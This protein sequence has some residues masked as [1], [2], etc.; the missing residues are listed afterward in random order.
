MNRYFLALLIVLLPSNA[1]PCSRT[2]PVDPAEMVRFA[3][4]IVVARA[5]DYD[6]A[7]SDHRITTTGVPD[8]VVRFEIDE[9][10]K[11]KGPTSLSL[12]GYLS[13]A[14]DFNEITVPYTFVRKG[15][16]SGSCFANSYREGGRFLLVLK[17]HKGAY[18]VDWYA[19][20]PTNEQLHDGE[21]P[22]L[23]W[24]RTQVRVAQSPN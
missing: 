17:L 9:W 4:L 5:V 23:V 11:G 10:V 3:D 6:R 14:D 21:D 12:H 2:T 20:G 16:R 15:G 18:N 13:A 24:V 8:S 22:W 7:P 19:L 1:Y